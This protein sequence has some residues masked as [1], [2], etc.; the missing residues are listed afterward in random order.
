MMIVVTNITSSYSSTRCGNLDHFLVCF[1]V[2]SHAIDMHKLLVGNP[3][4][5]F[6]STWNILHN[7]LNVQ[8][9]LEIHYLVE[10]IIILCKKS[11][12][13]LLDYYVGME[14]RDCTLS[15]S[16]SFVWGSMR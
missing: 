16:V 8:M 4:I 2:C 9:A 13:C 5:C 7:V 3:P 6:N 11:Y 10:S 1:E 14:R 12:L 15:L